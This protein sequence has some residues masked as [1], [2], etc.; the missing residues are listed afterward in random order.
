[1][2]EIDHRNK[3]FNLFH[4]DI[5]ICDQNLGSDM[6]NFNG[7][8]QSFRRCRKWLSENYLELMI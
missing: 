4:I 6:R 3:G 1:V 7:D 8:K 2:K 5:E